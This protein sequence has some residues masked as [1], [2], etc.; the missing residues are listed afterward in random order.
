MVFLRHDCGLAEMWNDMSVKARHHVQVAGDG[1]ETIV[2]AHGFGCDQTMW[3]ALAPS[4]LARYRVVTFDLIG[5]GKSDL[6][7]YDREKYAS[8]RG[9]A[10]DVLQIL[11]EV[12]PSAA[13]FVGHSVSAMIG[14]LAALEAPE[15]FAAQVWIGPSPCYVNEG[16]YVGGFTKLEILAM[17]EL[18]DRNYLGWA[19]EM[20]P[21]IMGAPDR[22]ELGAE[23]TS[24]FCSLDPE[25]ATHFARVTFLSD[26]RAELERYKAGALILQSSDDAI[27]PVAVGK[28]LKRNVANST[29]QIIDNIGHCPHLSA[30]R[31][32]AAAI[33]RFL[34]SGRPR[35]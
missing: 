11:E 33:T 31:S 26:H 13:I 2:F 1:S 22:P 5:S 20:A 14:M 29:L 35:F 34:E 16:D 30:P 10:S 27:A 15:R 3:R 12:S 23:L 17:L 8:L 25:I 4:F 7:A 24:N 9:H 6:A 28:Y 32:I 21:R 19:H 18:L